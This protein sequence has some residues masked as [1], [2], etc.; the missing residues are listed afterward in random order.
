TTI[1]TESSTTS[2]DLFI[3]TLLTKH[4]R[5]LSILSDNQVKHLLIY[6]I[7]KSVV[8]SQDHLAV[9]Y[10]NY[11]VRVRVNLFRVYNRLIRIDHRGNVNCCF[12]CR[13]DSLHGGHD[14][15]TE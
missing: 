12:L 6:K 14:P 8:L 5:E 9:E 3:S 4:I 15:E 7:Y 2:N 13:A 11:P 1:V 10:V